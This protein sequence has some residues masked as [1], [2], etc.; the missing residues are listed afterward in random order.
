[1]ALAQ[2]LNSS[3]LRSGGTDVTS[4]LAGIIGHFHMIFSV[5]LNVF[6]IIA[7]LA[8]S[9]G[10]VSSRGRDVVGNQSNN[11]PEVVDKLLELSQY[12]TFHLLGQ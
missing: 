11:L 5:V 12:D 1:M 6:D 10:R 2:G 4:G 7:F 8:F 3:K 9:L